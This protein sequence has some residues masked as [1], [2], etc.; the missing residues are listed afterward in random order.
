M[1]SSHISMHI[2]EGFIEKEE[3]PRG[4]LQLNINFRG[5]S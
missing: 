2:S 3:I 1:K 5:V 4:L